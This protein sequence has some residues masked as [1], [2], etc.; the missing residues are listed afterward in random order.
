MP[1][2]LTVSNSAGRDDRA[3][4]SSHIP[5]ALLLTAGILLIIV[6]A[7]WIIAIFPQSAPSGSRILVGLALLNFLLGI[8]LLCITRFLWLQ[9]RWREAAWLVW[10]LLIVSC[11]IINERTGDIEVFLQLLMSVLIVNSVICVCSRRWLGSLSM[12][13]GASFAWLALCRPVTPVEWFILV[14]AIAVAH[15]GQELS[16]GSRR[17]AAAARAT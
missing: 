16:S 2:R 5:K 11:A 13:S 12:I 6:Q 9:R 14:V 15:C 3:L 4:A 8:A 7:A 10:A 17:E 1:I